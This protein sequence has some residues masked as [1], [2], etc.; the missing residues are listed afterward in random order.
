MFK[1]K[2]TIKTLAIS[3]TV[4]LATVI[5]PRT[6]QAAPFAQ[7]P[8]ISTAKNPEMTGPSGSDDYK[9]LQ[10]EINDQKYQ[11]DEQT[12]LFSVIVLLIFGIGGFFSYSSLKRQYEIRITSIAKD[13]DTKV[14]AATEKLSEHDQ[15]LERDLLEKIRA[16]DLKNQDTTHR[17]L[18]EIYRATAYSLEPPTSKF[19]WQMR[20]AKQ[21]RNVS[22]WYQTGH[23]IEFMQ[24]RLKEA[25]ANA[26]LVT[27]A[28]KFTT[29]L[30]KEINKHIA[31]IQTQIDSVK[32]ESDTTQLKAVDELLGKIRVQMNRIHP[33]IKTP[34]TARK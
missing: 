22:D 33:F 6:S 8:T 21:V 19:L 17:A 4:V 9:M 24:G 12:G 25:F 2:S 29:E 18:A 27:S 16:A 11:L 20:S 31:A 10:T 23:G 1:S 15:A 14:N 26:G 30:E 32:T 5:A 28:H 13:F 7:A 34:N 3:L